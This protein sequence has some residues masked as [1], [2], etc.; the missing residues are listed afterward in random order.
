LLCLI[1]N[2]NNALQERHEFHQK[3]KGFFCQ[4]KKATD[5]DQ[6]RK[7]LQRSG[8]DIITDVDHD[9]AMSITTA[10]TIDNM[11]SQNKVRSLPLSFLFL[12][13]L[14]FCSHSLTHFIHS[15]IHSFIHSPIH[16]L[17]LPF[18]CLI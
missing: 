3:I 4:F 5:F 1:S 17:S 9:N 12:I 16:I 11:S 2:S 8:R 10:G 18:I 14:F 15:L 13:L 6:I 7:K